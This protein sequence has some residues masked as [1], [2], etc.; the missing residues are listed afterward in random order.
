MADKHVNQIAIG[1]LCAVVF[2][3]D[4]RKYFIAL[5]NRHF[6]HRRLHSFG[7]LVRERVELTPCTITFPL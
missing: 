4:L 2:E 7:F 1:D 3:Q 5:F 6:S